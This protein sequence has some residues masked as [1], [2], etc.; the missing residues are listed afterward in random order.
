MAQRIRALGR[1]CGTAKA[2]HD[3]RDEPAPS[4]ARAAD[5]RDRLLGRARATARC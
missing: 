3:T 1:L 2:R 4:T 5:V